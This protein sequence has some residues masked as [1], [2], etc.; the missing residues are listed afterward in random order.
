MKEATRITIE[1]GID[2]SDPQ[3]LAALSKLR[4][5]FGVYSAH[6]WRVAGALHA[7]ISTGVPR[8]WLRQKREWHALARCL[9]GS[10][11]EFGCIP[12]VVGRRG[13]GDA[14]AR[15]A[16]VAQATHRAPDVAD[17]LSPDA[18]NR[19]IE[20]HSGSELARLLRALAPHIVEPEGQGERP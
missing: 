8:R 17:L 12:P 2:L 14:L 13:L 7:Y 10:A 5:H 4:R 19:V 15:Y 6:E 11:R 16:L 1:L 9:Y 3:A 18:R 20:I